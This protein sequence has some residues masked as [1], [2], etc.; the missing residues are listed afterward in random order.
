[1][2]N[3]IVSCSSFAAIWDI[4][5]IR[6]EKRNQNS[7]EKSHLKIELADNRDVSFFTSQE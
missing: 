4:S 2:Q 6:S 5:S 3:Y 7:V 1:M